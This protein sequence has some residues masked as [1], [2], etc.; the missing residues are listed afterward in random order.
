MIVRALYGLKTS[1]ARWHDR[2]ADTLREEGFAPCEA[3]MN[4]WMREKDGLYKYICVYIDDL[5]IAMLDPAAFCEMLKSKHGYKLK[6]VSDLKYHLGCDFGLDQDGTYDYGPFKYMEKMMDAYE[7][8]FG[9]KPTG[10]SSPL[11]KGDHPEL[12]MSPELNKEGHA[13]YMSLVGQS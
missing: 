13:L 8:L 4:V 2:F 5:A 1:G 10:Y 11:E 12:D 6:G 7:C 3:D 9:E